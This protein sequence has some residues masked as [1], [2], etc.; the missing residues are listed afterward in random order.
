MLDRFIFCEDVAEILGGQ[1]VRIGG[2]KVASAIWDEDQSEL[3][4]T[5]GK[6]KFLLQVTEI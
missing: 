1:E 2:K 6:Q 4:V 5:I 3:I